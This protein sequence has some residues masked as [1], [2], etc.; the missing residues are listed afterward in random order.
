MISSRLRYGLL[1]STLGLLWMTGASIA[2]AQV[3]E[4]AWWSHYGQY[5]GPS[6][7]ARVQFEGEHGFYDVEGGRGQIWNVRYI[8]N[9]ENEA[10]QAVA[11]RWG[12]AGRDGWFHFRIL[13]NG[14]SF[15]GVW[16]Y[17]DHGSPVQGYW[18][19]RRSPGGGPGLPLPPDLPQ[20]P[21]YQGHFAPNL[22]IYYEPQRYSDGTFGARLIRPP[23]PNSPAAL[24]GFES[25]DVILELDGQRLATP[26]NVL[27]HTAQTTVRFINV[28]TGGQEMRTIFIP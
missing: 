8:R 12:F 3:S 23:A 15:H 22:G 20:P 10:V 16:G 2:T 24:A 26:S 14:E 11:G 13:D 17:G 4:S 21:I 27:A 7:R 9:P 6:T 5:S 25:G 1:A 19:G 28:R 18:N